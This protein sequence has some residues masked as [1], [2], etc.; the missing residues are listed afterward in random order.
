[1]LA[2]LVLLLGLFSSVVRAEPTWIA[3]PHELVAEPVVEAPVGGW[4]TEAGPLVSVHGDVGDRAAV[5]HL[6]DHAEASLDRLAERLGV[7]ANREIDVYVAPSQE[8][9]DRI[10]PGAPPDWAD[11]TAYA[12]SGLVFLR[13][14]G[15]RPGTASPLDQVLDHELVHVLLGSAFGARPVP[16]WLQEGLAQYYAGE[17]EAD[18]AERIA[19]GLFGSGLFHLQDLVAGFPSD[20]GRASLAYAQSADF[21]GW[22]AETY[23]PDSH[24]VL[25]AELVA[26][27]P[28]DMALRTATGADMESLDKAWRNRL[29]TPEN[30]LRGAAASGVFWLLPVGALLYGWSWRRKRNRARMKRWE[31]EERREDERSRL[32]QLAARR[33]SGQDAWVN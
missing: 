28:V 9:F 16:R 7:R 14:P 30:W 22:M 10:Q 11:G 1:M 26:A 20:A 29:V 3:T 15:I 33:R 27:R 6:A 12:R 31:E 18:D 23:G 2:L 8:M 24:R 19:R 25:I 32:A 13:S 4:Y 17:I 5:R 21:V